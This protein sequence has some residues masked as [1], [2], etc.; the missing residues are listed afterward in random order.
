MCEVLC[1]FSGE[2][3]LTFSTLGAWVPCTE[4]QK[5]SLV[6]IVIKKHSFYIGKSEIKELVFRQ[7]VLNICMIYPIKWLKMF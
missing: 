2:E 7:F 6:P 5:R 1:Y 4:E 3:K